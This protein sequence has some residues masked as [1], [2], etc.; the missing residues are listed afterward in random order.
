MR[1]TKFGKLT[2][3]ALGLAGLGLLLLSPPKTIA[4][5]PTTMNFQGKIVNFTGGTNITNPN[6]AYSIVFRIYNTSSPTMTTAC[7][8]T[9]SCLWEETQASVQLTNGIFQV[10]LGSACALT[11]ASCN[12]A[13]GGP[14]N[15]ASSNSLYLTM[16]FNGDTSGSN[17]G[18]MSPL[19]HITSVPFALQADNSA[20]LGGLASSAFAQL[21]QA[22][23][24]TS[25][26]SIQPA[27]N[28]VGL[29]VIF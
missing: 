17:G 9:A 2:V 20:T 18:F 4:A 28:I 14:I 22:A 29:T 8:T 26:V 6:N 11:S 3:L 5:N 24:F 25:S 1:I 21:A 13:A 15:F 16:Q 23:A 7:N 12:N 10:E 19:I 27:T